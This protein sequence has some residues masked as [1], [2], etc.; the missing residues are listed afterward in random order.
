MECGV[1]KDKCLDLVSPPKRSL[2]QGLSRQIIYLGTCQQET[3]VGELEQ[4]NREGRKVN[5]RVT[6]DLVLSARK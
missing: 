6:I 3:E 2:R 4:V 5:T 1:L